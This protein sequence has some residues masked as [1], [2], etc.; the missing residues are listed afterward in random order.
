MSIVRVGALFALLSLA[1]QAGSGPSAQAQMHDAAGAELVHSISIP[2][3]AE[4]TPHLYRGGQPD[5][6]AFADLKKMGIDIIIDMRSGDRKHERRV[7]TQLGMGYVQIPW[8]CPFPSD[9]PFAE[10]LKIVDENRDKKILVHC[11]LGDDRTGMAIA[12]YRM[13]KQGWSAEEAMSEMHRFGFHG[14]HYLICPG[15]A[16]YEKGFPDRLKS[17]SAFESLRKHP[18]QAK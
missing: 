1:V 18:D 3:F 6:A 16:S 15:L 10:F 9:K 7:V 4:V 5:D 2:R 12:A 8:H 17:S 14:V 11:R 13:A